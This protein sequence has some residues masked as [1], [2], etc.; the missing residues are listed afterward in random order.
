MLRDLMRAPNGVFR[1][2]TIVL[3]GDFRKTLPV[4][5]GASK[6]ELI[7][8][9]IA[10]SHLWPY[11]K[12]YTLKENMRLLRSRLTSEQQ[13]HS[14]Q[15][16]KWLLDVGNGEIKEP[17]AEREQDSSW[18]TI[19]PE[20]TVTVDEAGMSELIDFIYDDTTL[21]APTAGSL[22]EKVIVC[23]K[24]V[25]ADVVNAKILSNIEGHI[26]TYLSNDEAISLGTETS[27]TELLYPIEYLNTMTFPGLSPYELKLKVGLPIMLLRNVNLSGGLCNGTR[28][29]V[30]S[31]MSKLIEA[32][33]ITETRIGEK[34]FIHTIPF[35]HK[36]PNLSFTFKRKQFP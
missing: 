36:D 19:L 8:A 24:H 14:E 13:R 4:K 3:G 34:V 5:K 15:F 21:K 22:Q 10:E 25:T 12:V 27:E 16:A 28:M 26:K 2:K 11:F 23:P 1:G 20:Y 17:N 18:V 29:I 31:L 7:A 30:R 32:Q 6:E 35:T 33:I 9:S